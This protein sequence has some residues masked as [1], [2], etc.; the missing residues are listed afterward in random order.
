MSYY[1]LFM[2]PFTSCLNLVI[3]SDAG[4]SAQFAHEEVS[5]SCLRPHFY[6]LCSIASHN[7]FLFCRL[8]EYFNF[9]DNFRFS[10]LTLTLLMAF[11]ALN[12]STWSHQGSWMSFY[13]PCCMMLQPSSLLHARVEWSQCCDI[14]SRE[15]HHFSILSRTRSGNNPKP[16]MKSLPRWQ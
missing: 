16:E 12:N 3:A 7:N 8:S 13:H 11:N 15:L 6:M 9:H 1:I 4:G 14:L 10:M 2:S 5:Y